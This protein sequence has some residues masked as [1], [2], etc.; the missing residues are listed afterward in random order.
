M[1]APTYPSKVDQAGWGAGGMRFLTARS[2]RRAIRGMGAWRLLAALCLV[3]AIQAQADD[4]RWRNVAIGG[5]G[6]VSGLEFHP[7]APGVLYARTDIGGAY[8]W[9]DAG[10]RWIP[11]LD[12]LGADD[13]GRFGVES[14][15]LDPSDPDKVYLAIGTYLHARGDD[16]VILRSSDRGRTF[17]RAALPFKLG[18]NEQGRGNGER[19]AVDP[20]DGRVLL[21]GTRAH[22]LWRSDDGGARW[23]E[24]RGFPEIARSRAAWAKGWRDEVPIGIAFV[25]FDPASGAKGSP[26]RTLYAGV[27]TQDAGVYRSDDGGATWQAVPGQPTGLR[28]SHMVRDA[29]GRWLLS[30]GDEPGP[31]HMADGAVYRFDPADGSW[32]D[33][34]PLPRTPGGASGYGWGAVAVQAGD[35]DVLVATTFRRYVPGDD[36]Y[37]SVD[38]GRTWSA[39]FARSSF[40][41]STAP[42]T[43]DAKP[44]WM[45]DVEIDPHD[46]DRI[47]FVTGYGVWAS[48]NARAFDGGGTVQWEFPQAG[49]EETVPLSLASPPQGAHLVSGLGDVDG[50]VHDDLDVP[51]QRFAGVRFSNTESLAWAGQAPQVMVRTG[52]FHDR[53]EGA[54]RGAWSND[55]GRSWTAFAHEPPEGD[56]AGRITLAADGKRAIWQPRNGGHWLTADMGGR[57]QAVKGLPKTAVVEADKVDEAVYYA[58]DPIAGTLH[59]SGNGGVSFTQVQA[60]VGEIGDWFRPEIR[61][62]P[63]RMGE[64]WLTASWRGLLHWSPGKLER[65]PGVDN[66]HSVGLGRPAKEGD[67]P[68]LFVYGEVGGRLGLYRSDDNGRRWR[69]IDHDGMRFGGVVRHVTGDP[70]LHGRVYFGTE[71]R[72]IWYGDPQ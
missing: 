27:S 7:S 8:R 70:R 28:P 33:L 25:A 48:R 15:A 35:P 63:G 4:Y 19:L 61:P 69:R 11:L 47:W 41:H 52:H 20:N 13:R 49:F 3:P 14:L 37:R 24:V 64:A 5:G 72:G 57:W 67:P 51:Q 45:A 1:G 29:R 55:G 12:G 17:Q 60:Q 38:G 16:G 18:G 43:A 62:H 66:A 2:T 10:R 50:F 56:G 68:V 9:D 39:M 44:H 31:N 30:Y 22:G 59:V 6:F 65:V 42:W 23:Q 53:P 21:L 58:F 40:E 26:S 46:A 36:V 71:G 34:T 32:T 54:V